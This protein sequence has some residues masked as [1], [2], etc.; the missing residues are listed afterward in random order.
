MSSFY[1]SWSR[2]RS[3]WKKYPEPVKNGPAPQH[4]FFFEHLNIV[5]WSSAVHEEP[6]DVVALCCTLWSSR[7][8]LAGRR[9]P[10]REEFFFEHLNIVRWSSAVHVEPEDVVALCCML[11]S[12]RLT[13]AGHS[14]PCLMSSFLCPQGP[15]LAPADITTHRYLEKVAIHTAKEFWPL[16]SSIK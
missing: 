7:L 8:K 12:G 16:C 2:S 9:V 1:R 15:G 6:E 13:H 14:D 4:C 10:L 11:W 3:R 5:R